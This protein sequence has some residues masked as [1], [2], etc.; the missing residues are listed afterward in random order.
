MTA[1]KASQ[2]AKNKAALATK[3][4][5]LRSEIGSLQQDGTNS[6]SKYNYISN[7]AMITAIRAHSD[8]CQVNIVPEVDKWQERDYQDTKGKTV[9]RTIVDMRFTIIDM[10]TGH[11][12]VYTFTGAEQDTGG[13]SFQQAVTQ[14]TKYFYF[15][16]FDV[17]SKDE[18][19]GDS[20]TTEAPKEAKPAKTD[21]PWLDKGSDKW[22]DAIKYLSE[23]GTIDKIQESYKINKKD[24]EELMSLALEAEEV[25]S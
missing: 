21:K 1:T 15:K 23:G 10:E 9:I 12:E 6:Y 20:K 7:E 14:C 19:D 5:K 22:D 2:D 13:K 11:T 18:T 24:Q 17:T 16:L 4:S 3:L 8:A 25:G